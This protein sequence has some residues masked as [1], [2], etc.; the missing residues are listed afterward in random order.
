MK[1][2][3][4]QFSNK[5]SEQYNKLVEI[6]Q[7]MVKKYCEINNYDYF[8]EEIPPTMIFHDMYFHKFEMMLKYIND[9][10]YLVWIDTDAV[11]INPL[12]SIESLLEEQY[13]A[14]ISKDV[15]VKIECLWLD[16]I[17][18]I[19]SSVK[20]QNNLSY[21]N[22]IKSLN[23]ILSKQNMPFLNWI[24]KI[25]FNPHG[26]CSGF[27]IIKNSEIGKN[28]LKESLYLKNIFGYF[29]SSESPTDQEALALIL[30]K[31]EVNTKIF[32]YKFHG[33]MTYLQDGHKDEFSYDEDHNFLCH[34]YSLSLENRIKAHKIIKNNKFWKKYFNEN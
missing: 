11:P 23:D 7:L 16:Y 8:F 34:M 9:Y 32:D 6:N 29:K 1:I 26:F 3:F 2:A 25:A 30:Q 15:M 27:F 18:N 22:D 21:V 19:I 28:I 10:D 14:Y 33:N 4:C 17:H 13:D 24:K 20:N 12:I 5:S 31:Y